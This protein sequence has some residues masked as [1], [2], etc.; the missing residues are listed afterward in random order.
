MAQGLIVNLF[1]KGD[2]ADHGNY[3]GIMLLSVVGS[4]VQS[5]KKQYLDCGGKSIWTVVVNCMKNKEDFR[6]GVV[7]IMLV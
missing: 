3:R 4:L 1:R 5:G 2:K 6:A 7:W